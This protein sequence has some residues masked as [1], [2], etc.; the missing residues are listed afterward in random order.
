MKFA[1]STTL[2]SMLSAS[3]LHSPQ[4]SRKNNV[5]IFALGCSAQ[6][7]GTISTSK[8]FVAAQLAF[9]LLLWRMQLVSPASAP[10]GANF[11]Q[12]AQT[13]QDDSTINSAYLVVRRVSDGTLLFEA[14]KGTGTAAAADSGYTIASGTKW[15]SAATIMKLVENG[16]LRLDSTL[17]E[18]GGSY[19]QQ[20]NGDGR[21]NITLHEL[22]SFTSGLAF[23]PDANSDDATDA[24]VGNNTF[25]LE[26]CSQNI[27]DNNAAFPSAPRGTFVYGSNHLVVA[28]MMAEKATGMSWN[29]LFVATTLAPLGLSQGLFQNRYTPASNPNLAGT[30]WTSVADYTTWLSAYASSDG[31]GNG[32]VAYFNDSVKMRALMEADATPQPQVPIQ[33][34]PFAVF[35]MGAHY[36]LGNW[37]ECPPGTPANVFDETC[38]PDWGVRSSAGAFGFY[39]WINLHH[40]FFGVMGVFNII[41]PL[42]S[43][44]SVDLGQKINTAVV[45][46]LVANNASTTSVSTS[47]P[48]SSTT[49]TTP[50]PTCGSCNTNGASHTVLESVHTII[51]VAF[52]LLLL[53]SRG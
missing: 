42:A 50:P 40:D 51:V 39:P 6:V 11:T 7:R 32:G 13:F 15:I 5:C 37:L 41:N 26:S 3:I 53:N 44:L 29:D 48:S 2:T 23:N 46:A 20:D 24:C 43:K 30:L 8:M 36:G 17:G 27:F 4:V 35:G 18:V 25:T 31:G 10:T 28:G 14:S 34:S 9:V 16:A 19:F 33:Y 21:A 22:L 45:S 52:G 38:D 1:V 47:G 49:T 12:A